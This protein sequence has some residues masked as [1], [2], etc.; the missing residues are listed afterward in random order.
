LWAISGE[1]DF[2]LY[3]PW[4]YEVRDAKIAEEFDDQRIRFYRCEDMERGAIK[5]KNRQGLEQNFPLMTLSVA[6]ISTATR[7]ICTMPGS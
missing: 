2:V 5:T 7:R 4:T 1:T 6:I 3:P